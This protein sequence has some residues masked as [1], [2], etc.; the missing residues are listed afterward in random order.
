M[1]TIYDRISS[2]LKKRNKSRK[3]LCEATGISYNTLTSLYR[4]Q[5]ENMKLDTVKLIAGYFGVTADYL[6]TGNNVGLAINEATEDGYNEASPNMEL[7]VVRIMKKLN[8][9]D[10]TILLAKAYELEDREKREE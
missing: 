10:K 3:D 5:S 1:E 2:L 6:I 7:E 9:R 4:R 8:P